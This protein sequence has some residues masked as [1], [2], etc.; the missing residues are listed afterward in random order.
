[1][2]SIV[3]FTPNKKLK[4]KLMC[5]HVNFKFQTFIHELYDYVSMSSAQ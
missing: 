5:D 1:M 2:E 4:D 3:S